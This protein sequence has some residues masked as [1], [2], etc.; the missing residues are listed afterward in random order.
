MRFRLELI[1]NLRKQVAIR[2][3]L[4]WWYETHFVFQ[5]K[6]GPIDPCFKL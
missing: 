2:L 4:D 1:L 5:E 3:G 6:Q